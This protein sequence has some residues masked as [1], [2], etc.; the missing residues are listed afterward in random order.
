MGVRLTRDK[1]E[2]RFLTI[3]TLVV[4]AIGIPA[5]LG[6]LHSPNPDFSV[7]LKSS[8]FHQRSPASLAP[9]EVTPH[10]S[11]TAEVIDFSCA[12]NELSLTTSAQQV[13]LRTKDCGNAENLKITNAVNE[14]T[15]TWFNVGNSA[16]S[17][18][19]SLTA[20]LN[21]LVMETPQGKRILKIQ[22]HRENHLRSPAQ[23]SEQ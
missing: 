17:D 8:D 22:R 21:E 19:L 7:A 13:R 6:L 2:S 1:I 18:Y 23:A 15:G 11:A 16:T 12:N 20:G 10:A 9:D 14:S 4:A 3:L 5:F